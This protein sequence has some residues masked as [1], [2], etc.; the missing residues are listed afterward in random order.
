MVDYNLH[1]LMCK[2]LYYDVIH[3]NLNIHMQMKTNVNYISANAEWNAL[4]KILED[5]GVYITLLS[6]EENLVDMVFAANSA[7]IYKN[8]AIVSTFKAIPRKDESKYIFKH[9]FK[10]NFDIT[11][12][13]SDFEGAGDA[14]FSHIQNHL[15]LGHGFRSDI[16]AFNDVSG[17]FYNNNFN[18]VNI[19]S[20]C[21]I[22]PKWYH[23]D[24][25]FCPINNDIIMLYEDAFDYNSLLEIYNV[26][27]INKSIKVSYDDAINFACNS[28]VVNNNVNT[29]IIGHKFSD[30]LKKIFINNNLKFIENN[31]DQF[32][33]SGGSCKCCVLDITNYHIN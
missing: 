25:C 22:N 32:L 11:E 8:L 13:K 7:L 24:T 14:L 15:W 18:S 21:L 27:D 1:F 17:V 26:Y 30:A 2:P 6:P 12:C 10:N 16:G 4:K 33:L 31:M 28:I 5:L 20:L 9:F 23:L 3:K 29:F 19:H